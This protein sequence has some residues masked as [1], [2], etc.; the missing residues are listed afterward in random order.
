M[1]RAKRWCV[2]VIVPAKNEADSIARCVRS[3]REA[4]RT[5]D[6]FVRLW[7]VVVADACTDGT[8]A[9]AR[10]A[11]HEDGEVIECDVRSAG[12]ARTIGVAA[13][14][15]HFGM[16]PADQVWLANTDADTYVPS[17]WLERH[18]EFADAGDIGVAGIV[19]LD[20]E[21]GLDP[22]AAL[23]QR[24]FHD[25]Y[26]VAED[27]T[28]THVHGANLGVRADAYL[29]VGG[30]GRLALAEDHCLW[31]RLK[32][33]GWPLRSTVLSRVITSGRLRGRAAGGFADTLQRHVVTARV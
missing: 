7:I 3:I 26:L 13:A 24:L 23:V 4:H 33:A 22:D 9:R 17:D 10:A 1:I 5:L 27:G 29:D 31:N 8:V 19:E 20:V 30:W 32:I 11:L 2:G 25:T 28:H 6:R 14:L 15:G 21:P 16:T 18:L 12:A